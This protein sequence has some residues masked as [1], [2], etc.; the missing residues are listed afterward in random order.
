MSYVGLLEGREKEKDKARRKEK[1]KENG[2]IKTRSTME[3][4]VELLQIVVA[5]ERIIIFLSFKSISLI[6]LVD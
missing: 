5:I 2:R 4:G 6:G 1:G 3:S